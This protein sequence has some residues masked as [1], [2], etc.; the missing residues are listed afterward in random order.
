MLICVNVLIVIQILMSAE[1]EATHVYRTVKILLDHSCVA[2]IL[3]ISST[4]MDTPVM[5]LK[6]DH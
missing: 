3:A 4:V 5:V 6:K 2:A 1:R